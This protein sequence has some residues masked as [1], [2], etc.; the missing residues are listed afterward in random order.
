MNQID[1]IDLNINNYDISSL[2]SFFGLNEKKMNETVL[3][4]K[5]KIIYNVLLNDNKLTSKKKN[6]FI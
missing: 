4:E 1:D 3:E 5:K 6:K 2:I